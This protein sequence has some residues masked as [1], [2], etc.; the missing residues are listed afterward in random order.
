[1][2]PNTPDTVRSSNGAL[3]LGK[4]LG[5]GGEGAVYELPAS[6]DRVAKIYHQPVSAD[7]AAKIEAMRR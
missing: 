4:V 7:K 3:E 2:K 6:R 1:M 5:R